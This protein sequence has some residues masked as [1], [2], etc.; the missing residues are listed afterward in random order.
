MESGMRS[1]PCVC[2]M[3]YVAFPAGGEGVLA[4]TKPSSGPFLS[5]VPRHPHAFSFFQRP[6]PTQ[7]TLA[8]LTCTP[9]SACLPIN[10]AFPG[11]ALLE[12]FVRP[13]LS[14]SEAVVTSPH[15]L[16][17][18]GR[19]ERADGSGTRF[20]G[21]SLGNAHLRVRCG[22]EGGERGHCPHDLYKAGG[23]SIVGSPGRQHPSAPLHPL[24]APPLL[25]LP[26]CSSRISSQPCA[27]PALSL[28]QAMPCPPSRWPRSKQASTAGLQ[29]KAR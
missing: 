29:P 26:P 5:E 8:G 2:P 11:H 9:C 1:G 19:D 3:A 7:L 24:L 25:W 4:K 22:D 21:R 6:A 28:R 23:I 12:R 13:A 14:G 16:V 18:R 10:A 17:C 27:W 15:Q 20:H